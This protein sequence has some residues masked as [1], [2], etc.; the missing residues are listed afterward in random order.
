MSFIEVAA[1]EVVGVVVVVAGVVVLDG[2]FSSGLTS[3]I[4]FSVVLDGA[5]RRIGGG[6][7]TLSF[8]RVVA[9]RCIG[10]GFGRTFLRIGDG[11]GTVSFLRAG[12]ER[13][14]GD[15]IGTGSFLL[16]VGPAPPPLPTFPSTSTLG[17]AADARRLKNSGFLFLSGLG[18]VTRGLAVDV[19]APSFGARRLKS[20]FF[21]L[22][23]EVPFTAF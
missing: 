21:L 17:L 20:V 5:E 1:A 11:F 22:S 19:S 8:L 3:P 2:A 14:V 9:E 10:D 13:C 23:L 16:A 18:V 4:F 12:V 15:G 6:F 7:G